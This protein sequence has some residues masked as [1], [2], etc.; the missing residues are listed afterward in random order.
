VL[1]INNYVTKKYTFN[2]IIYIKPVFCCIYKIFCLK[3][4][5][6]YIGST[7]NFYKRL[8]E[9][10]R[11]LKQNNHDNKKLQ[12]SYNKYG[13]D[14][15]NISVLKILKET[16][17]Q[18][19]VEQE[20]LNKNI[21]KNCF[22]ININCL[23]PPVSKGKRP[24][25]LKNLKTGEIK[26]WK[27]CYL[28]AKEINCN[29]SDLVALLKKT[30]KSVKGWCLVDTKISETGKQHSGHNT[31]IYLKILNIKNNQILEFENIKKAEKIIKLSRF[32]IKKM[33]KNNCVINNFK[34]LKFDN[35]KNYLHGK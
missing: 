19:L 31:W 28:A 22:N 8:S 10:L 20:F 21:N 5:K 33:I 26:H 3:N 23:K 6:F 30:Q 9:H 24:I 7:K 18:F 12:N 17:N 34:I 27:F 4:K 29:R 2:E 13:I 11:K 35:Y 14:F 1:Y 25:T 15:F 16:E 32:K